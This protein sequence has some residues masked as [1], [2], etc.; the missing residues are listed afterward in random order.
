MM[1]RIATLLLAAALVAVLCIGATGCE[2]SSSSVSVS[3]H[4]SYGYGPGWGAGWRG[5]YYPRGPVGPPGYW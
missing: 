4:G 5:T 3:V 2:S 1:K